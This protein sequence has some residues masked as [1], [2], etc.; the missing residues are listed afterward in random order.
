M[1]TKLTDLQWVARAR[2]G[3]E[4]MPVITGINVDQN[5]K[6]FAATDRHRLHIAAAEASNVADGLYTF[7]KPDSLGEAIEGRYPTIDMVIP[8]GKP[9]FEI[10]AP[11]KLRSLALA[12]DAYIRSERANPSTIPVILDLPGVKFFVNAKYLA[13]ALDGGITLAVP[14][15]ITSDRQPLSLGWDK[16][17]RAVIMPIHPGADPE[18]RFTACAEWIKPL[19]AKPLTTQSRGRVAKPP[20]EAKAPVETSNRIDVQAMRVSLGLSA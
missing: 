12:A 5:G 16:Y 13:D 11:G 20:A 15:L 4:A 6:R 18:Y 7:V 19:N 9:N 3:D 14:L 8:Q 1:T 2:A 17:R 10:V